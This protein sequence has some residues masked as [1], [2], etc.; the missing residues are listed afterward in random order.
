MGFGFSLALTAAGAILA[1]AVN[2]PSSTFDVNTIG[3]ILFAV[4]IVGLVLST[5]FWSSWG[6]PGALTRQR[7]TTVDPATGTTTTEEQTRSY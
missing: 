4:G 6:G 3:Y 1:W 5:V 7:R 2:A